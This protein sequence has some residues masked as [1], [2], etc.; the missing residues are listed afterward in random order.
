MK[1]EIVEIM[2]RENLLQEEWDD[3][4]LALENERRQKEEERNQKEFL[5]QVSVRTFF[6]LGLTKEQIAE[7]L[8]ISIT[9]V[10]DWLS[11]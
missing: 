4:V 9:K 3:M 5:M 2:Q 8:A 1:K 10:E 6:E 7:K 11:L